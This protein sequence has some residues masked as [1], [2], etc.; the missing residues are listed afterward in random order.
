MMGIAYPPAKL[1]VDP[2]FRKTSSLRKR[3]NFDV[4]ARSPSPHDKNSYYVICRFDSLAQRGQMEEGYY[5]SD[6]WSQGPRE[7]TLV[8]I[9]KLRADNVLELD[10][11]TV[12]GLHG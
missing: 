9:E 6:D 8:L 2:N 12:Q 5:A 10:E 3:W 7:A 11:V 1:T 4:V